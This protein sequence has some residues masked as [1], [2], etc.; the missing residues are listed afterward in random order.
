MDDRSRGEYLLLL[1]RT[2]DEFLSSLIGVTEE[3]SRQKPAADRW[4]ILECTEHV[5]NAERGMLIMITQRC[6]PRTAPAPDREQELLR[7]AADRTRKHN[8]PEQVRPTGRY[9]TLAEAVEKF[10]E[11][12]ARSIDYV[13][14]CRDD[15]RAIEMQHPMGG[16]INAQECLA[17]LAMH[18]SRHAAQIREIRESLGL[19]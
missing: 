16:K 10:A 18:P 17:I 19:I 13:S 3:Q 14:N 2:R 1:A 15:L 6:T 7:H 12:R 5:V 11:H 4:S 8:A 9:A